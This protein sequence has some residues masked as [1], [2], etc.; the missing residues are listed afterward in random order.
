MRD[1]SGKYLFFNKYDTF[2]IRKTA[3]T[4]LIK[5]IGRNYGISLYKK[6]LISEHRKNYI[7]RDNNCVVKVSVSMYVTNFCERTSS[8]TS[9][10]IKIKLHTWFCSIEIKS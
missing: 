4:I 1:L 7:F 5:K 6:A 3:E 8:K 10:N 9:V 2:L